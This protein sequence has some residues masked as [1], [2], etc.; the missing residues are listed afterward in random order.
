MEPGAIIAVLAALITVLAVAIIA[1]ATLAHGAQKDAREW[2]D[3][4]WA[5][6]DK[7]VALERRLR[8]VL[9]SDEE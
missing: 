4:L 9:D 5:E 1:T 7:R 8:R 2:R 3:R 6:Q